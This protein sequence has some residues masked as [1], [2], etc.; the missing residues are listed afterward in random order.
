MGLLAETRQRGALPAIVV[1]VSADLNKRGLDAGKII[2]EVAGIVG[3]GGG[4]RP[5]FAQGSGKDSSKLAD[6]LARANEIISR[7]LSV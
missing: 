1:A 6:A 4:G 5:T 7:A 3:G 2:R